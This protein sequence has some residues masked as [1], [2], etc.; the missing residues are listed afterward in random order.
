M[1]MEHIVRIRVF[2]TN[3]ETDVEI[4]HKVF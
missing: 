3:I 4:V 1:S 2:M